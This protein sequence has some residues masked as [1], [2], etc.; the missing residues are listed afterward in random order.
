MRFNSTAIVA[1]IFA[2]LALISFRAESQD[3]RSRIRED[4]AFATLR[5]FDAS[6]TRTELYFGMHPGATYGYDTDLGES[7]IPP[8]PIP[9][10]FEARFLDLPGDVR[11]PAG[12]TYIDIRKK[13]GGVQT[14]TFIVYAQ[15]LN[16]AYPVTIAWDREEMRSLFG[17]AVMRYRN[18]SNDDITIDMLEH[19]YAT[20]DEDECGWIWLTV[21]SDAPRSE[22]VHR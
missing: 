10:A 14:D 18:K 2:G 1:A 16:G 9:V 19:H 6:G 13:T 21:E 12:G 4:V 7:A 11:E 15:P 17:S 8:I 22:E 5:V 3:W 20:F